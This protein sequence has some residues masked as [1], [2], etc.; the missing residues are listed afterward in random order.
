MGIRLPD[1]YTHTE[2]AGF[3]SAALI[4]NHPTIRDSL[5]NGKVLIVKDGAQYW[6]IKITYP[7]LLPEEFALIIST[8]EKS[9]RTGESIDI[10]LPQYSPFRVSSTSGMTVA[11]GYQG[12]K[13]R[14]L[15]A[16][17]EIP[18]PGD[19]IQLGNSISKKV[20]RITDIDR[21]NAT[22]LD[23]YLY[24]DLVITTTGM[25]VPIFNNILFNTVLDDWATTSDINTDG[26]YAGVTIAFRENM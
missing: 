22:T 1:P 24:P 19:L 3:V 4:D 12:S 15:N 25:E 17:T 9:K 7:E 23:I 5:R 21:V 26:L 8:I 10:L 13:L 18:Y 6:G 20:Y 16:G 11:Q 14:V 2:A